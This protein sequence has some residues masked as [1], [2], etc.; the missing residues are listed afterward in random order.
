MIKDYGFNPDLVEFKDEDYVF[1]GFTKLPREVIQEDGQWQKFAPTFE[2]QAKNYETSGCTI[3]GG[4][5]QIETYINKV[6]GYEPNYDEAFNYIKAGVTLD[7]ANPQRGYES[8]RKDG[9]IDNRPMPATYEEFSDPDSIT[10]SMER[11]GK[12]WEYDFKHEW[13]KKPS[14]EDIKEALKYSPIAIG[15]TAWQEENGLYVD[16]G[17]P[18]THWC[19]CDGY[20]EDERGII[21]DAFDSYKHERKLIHPDHNISVA[22]RIWIGKRTSKGHSNMFSKWWCR[23]IKSLKD[24]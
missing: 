13:L 18:N 8:F 5:N 17:M 14:K 4:Q 15:V 7:G 12:E 6:F 19:D 23:V 21:L 20:I 16:N 11:E 2:P 10:A 9:L 22:K 24:I 1:G 3:F